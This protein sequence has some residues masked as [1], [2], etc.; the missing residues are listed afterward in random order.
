M[1]NS[2]LYLCRLIFFN[3]LIVAFMLKK[4]YQVIL[5]HSLEKLVFTVC[6]FMIIAAQYE[7]SVFNYINRGKFG[8]FV[9]NLEN[10]QATLRQHTKSPTNAPNN[11]IVLMQMVFLFGFALYLSTIYFLFQPIELAFETNLFLTLPKMLVVLK[12]FLSV[13]FLLIFHGIGANLCETLAQ[14]DDN[15]YFL[16]KTYLA[17]TWLL[18]EFNG[19][20]GLQSLIHYVFYLC[21]NI[22]EMFH[23]VIMMMDT[24]STT[25][26]YKMLAMS[27]TVLFTTVMLYWMAVCHMT[28]NQARKFQNLWVG[29]VRKRE[30]HVSVPLRGRFIEMA[31]DFFSIYC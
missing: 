14:P 21:W 13:H 4:C 31:L 3:V 23:F 22:Y 8:Q 1:N 6:L 2:K 27:Y 28:R 10:F 18:R 20:F 30:T 19:L 11:Y 17:Y 29:S 16:Y 15:F 26:Y 9:R 7:W 12:T 25:K 24:N 5:E